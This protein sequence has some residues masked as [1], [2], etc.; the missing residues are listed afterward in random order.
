MRKSIILPV[1]A[2]AFS[3]SC[4][5]QP[6]ENI[7]DS[8]AFSASIE[9]LIGK[10]SITSA[11]KVEWTAGDQ[12]DINGAV[13]SATP[14]NDATMAVFNYESGTAPESPYKAI[15]PASLSCSG[16]YALPETQ[17][18]VPGGFNAPMYAESDTR[19]LSFKN[20]CGVF[21]FS[22]K[23]TYKVKSVTV[24]AN[25]PVCGSFTLTTDKTLSLS[26]N[27]KT[28][29]LDCGADGVQLDMDTATNFYV[30]LPPQEYS[31]GMKLVVNGTNGEIVE[32]TTTCPVQIEQSNIY[33]FN[34]AP[35][36]P[37]FNENDIVFS[38]ASI[39][40]VH[41][42]NLNT[43]PANKFTSALQQLKAK[44][45]E[46]DEDG[47]D[48]VLISGDFIDSGYLGNY[49]ITEYIKSLYQGQLDPT[50]VPL[51][52]SI[53]NHDA[54]WNSSMP[55]S[56]KEIYKIFG[57]DYY[58]A[59]KDND[60]RTN[61][62]CRHC[63]VGGYHIL[64]ISPVGDA[65]PS[66]AYDPAAVAWLDSQLEAIT[67]DN[68][69]Q[70]V[71][72]STH[73][74]VYNTVYGSTLVYGSLAWYTT[75]LT[76]V[77]K[78]YPQA[79]IFGGHLHFP[80]ND[81][82]SIWQGEF[83]SMGCASVRYMA[84]D[85]G[86]YMN[87]HNATTMADKDEYSEGLLI[88]FDGNGNMRATRM[89][90]YRNAEIGTPW[91][92]SYPS[93]DNSHLARYNHTTL[94]A[95]NTAPHLRGLDVE[96][97]NGQ[98]FAKFPAGSDDEFV[99]HYEINVW[100]NAQVQKTYKIL[101]DFYR[102]PQPSQMKSNWTATLGSFSKGTYGIELIAYDSWGAKSDKLV[103]NVTVSGTVAPAQ[104]S[105]YS[106]IDFAGGTITD[107]LGR[108]T[109]TNNGATV[110]KVSVSHKGNTYSVDGVSLSAGK[111][112][113]GVFTGM[114]DTDI[115][116][117]AC[118]SFSVEAFYVDKSPGSAVHGIFCATETGGWG[119][120]TRATG[121][122]Y[123]I[124]GDTST[125]NYYVN[126]DATSAASKTDLTH[127]V[128]VY[129]YSS[130]KIKIYV[131]GVLS[132][133]ATIPGMYKVGI[134]DTFN[135]FAI[136]A[137]VRNGAKDVDFQCTNMVVVDAKFYQGAMTDSDVATAYSNAVNSLK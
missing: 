2:V 5:K 85:N 1:I 17:T 109:L 102:S 130:K 137:D 15:Y 123:F 10:T 26:G 117:M 101:A 76:D 91:V 136:G 113:S 6:V 97:V 61:Y 132:K 94:R 120:A 40:D 37:E 81:P 100:A 4:A 99:H 129:D 83:T 43:A 12:V 128:G 131:N 24:T 55:T 9:Q 62:E 90:F 47:L 48:A 125:S 3:V 30:Y 112:I 54:K 45:S 63:V 77:L 118:K 29:S 36:S 52:Y 104:L 64:C 87:M 106:D 50:K 70:Y 68:P 19:S 42:D 21:C 98:I 92:T 119:L 73:P 23:G 51:I 111:D 33:T 124:T 121:V 20:I 103:K 134:G 41:V 7:V 80:L 110:G 11:Y 60:A 116:I 32:K 67:K 34:W 105:V 114:S 122:P 59:D 71:L 72:I 96:E 133:S 46:K 108:A 93:G 127:V 78:K 86:G 58:L 84:I 56:A 31:A 8:N 75:A 89:D 39:S 35:K 18:Y 65:G 38:I 135:R 44:A 57:P 28:V 14:Q 27:C 107:K 74:M 49:Y 126:V 88:Q 79:I 66:A 13:Y 16:E 95:A 25:E 53:G 69:E 22:L 82:R 115:Y